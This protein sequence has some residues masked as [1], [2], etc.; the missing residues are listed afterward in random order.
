M[1]LEKVDQEKMNT[2]DSVF[3]VLGMSAKS[4]VETKALPKIAERLTEKLPEKLAERMDER[5]VQTDIVVKTTADEADF[6]F[7]ILGSQK[8]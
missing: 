2:F 6:L 7:D 5:G 1:L 3:S 8:A 4:F